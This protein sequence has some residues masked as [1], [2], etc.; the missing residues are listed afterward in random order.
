MNTP[1]DDVE[2][3]RD[4]AENGEFA[5]AWSRA[6]AYTRLIQ[7]LQLAGMRP[8]AEQASWEAQIFQAP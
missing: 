5:K 8:E 6:E 7:A 3:L 2:Q 1:I 4:V